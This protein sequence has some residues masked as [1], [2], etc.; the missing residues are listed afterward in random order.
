MIGVPDLTVSISYTVRRQDVVKPG[1]PLREAIGY[2]YEEAMSRRT[3]VA[4]RPPSSA[5][6]RLTFILL[7][8]VAKVTTRHM[9]ALREAV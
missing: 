1:H 5:P 6:K 9:F 8:D 3:K 2:G 4:G 7:A